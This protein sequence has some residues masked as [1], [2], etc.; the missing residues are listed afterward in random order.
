MKQYLIHLF[1]AFLISVLPQ[2]G[3][4]QEITG[5][6]TGDLDIQGTKLTV[7]FHVAAGE[8]G[9]S[10]TM[11]SP[12]QGAYGIATD[13]TT[14]ENGILTIKASALA[15]TFEG[16]LAKGENK[17]VGTFTQRGTGFPL[18]MSQASQ[19]EAS[20]AKNADSPIVGSWGGVLL[21]QGTKL[22]IVFHVAA[23]GEGYTSKMD[24][25]N[26]N[27]F[28]IATDETTYEDGVLMIKA[29]AMGLHFKA[30]LEEGNEK[31]SGTFTQGGMALPLEMDRTEAQAEPPKKK[32]RP[33]D[34][35]EFPYK[36]EEVSYPVEQGGHSMA[37]TLTI[38][39]DGNFD[40]VVV[41]I[42]GSGA[43]N[44]NE[45]L[46]PMNHRPF[47][48][49]SDYLTRNGIAV[50][51]YDDRG[52]AES[53]GDHG[54]ATSRDFANDAAAGVAYL[55]SRKD[56]KGKKIGLMGHSEGG[57]IAPIVAS[58]NKEVDFIALLAGPGIAIPELMLLQ[59]QKITEAS[60]ESAES[61]EEDIRV[62]KQAFAIVQDNADLSTEELEETLMTFFVQAFEEMSEESKAKIAD[63]D[64]FLAQQT[65]QLTNPWF[66]YFMGFDPDTY[67]SK[68]SCPVLAVN[69]E[70]DLQV[71]PKENLAGIEK[72]L[73]KAG[74]KNVTIKEFKKM[75]H[76]FQLAETGSPTEYG[77]IEETFNEEAMKFIADWVLK[78]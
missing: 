76:L 70:L 53:T 65:K 73:K 12:K 35:T 49:L 68:V 66:R 21:V 46:G 51:R 72:S 52:V 17:L 36:Q 1:I 54:T 45:E 62:S 15:M 48:V 8:D 78:Q 23:E 11:D 38:P 41:L 5:T 18:E 58:E 28:G 44:R 50:L 61:I 2:L 43:Q 13:G 22:P 69:G 29:A 56:M 33:Q 42:S 59:I 39:E 75:N 3:I 34:P 57:M 37:G 64:V 47:L 19:K 60:G 77:D 67:L 27:A 24:S 7:V 31:L 55:R 4:A 30:S 10:T 14:Y 71:T 6:W 40:Q 32:I 9:Y 16:S 25:P 74:N 63:K 26:Q 20:P